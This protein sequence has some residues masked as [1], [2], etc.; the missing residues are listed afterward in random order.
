MLSPVN[1]ISLEQAV[2]KSIEERIHKSITS[3]I[4]TIMETIRSELRVTIDEI[5]DKKVNELR[6]EMQCELDIQAADAKLKPLSETEIFET[7][8]RRDNIK[9]IGLQSIHRES[10]EETAN[11]I[12][13]LASEMNVHVDERDISIAHWLPS[14]SAN[15]PVIVKFTGRVSK[16][17]MLRSKRNLRSSSKYGNV[18]IYE[19]LSKARL[20]FFAK[21]DPRIENAWSREGVIFYNWE[22]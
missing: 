20:N 16:I 13:E 11:L 3:L 18:R 8:N 9:I 10:Y 6:S 12:K 7:Y 15:K 21:T 19:D 14:K 4:P 2:V 17:N 1:K 5:V 22:T